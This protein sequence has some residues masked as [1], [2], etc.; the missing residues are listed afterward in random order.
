MYFSLHIYFFRNGLRVWQT[1]ILRICYSIR[2]WIMKVTPKLI[3]Y[4]SFLFLFQVIN[5]QKFPST[6]ERLSKIRWFT[7]MKRLAESMDHILYNHLLL[8][9]WLLALHASQKKPPSCSDTFNNMSGS[10]SYDAWKH[11]WSRY[12]TFTFQIDATLHKIYTWLCSV[13]CLCTSITVYGWATAV[14][15]FMFIV[16]YL[17]EKNEFQLFIYVS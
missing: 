8:A 7:S 6:S 13:R 4:N 5:M 1:V 16:S 15:F 9:I 10:I 17:S 3:A 11:L 14:N 12:W 2:N